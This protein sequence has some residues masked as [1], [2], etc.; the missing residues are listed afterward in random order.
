MASD[1]TRQL[2]KSSGF[3]YGLDLAGVAGELSESDLKILAAMERSK[4]ALTDYC[5]QNRDRLDQVLDAIYRKIVSALSGVDRRSFHVVARVVADY[6]L[7]YSNIFQN[8][9]DHEEGMY[10]ESLIHTTSAQFGDVL[11]RDALE[12]L[13]TKLGRKPEIDEA[14]AAWQLT[15]MKLNNEEEYANTKLE[16]A[17]DVVI[18]KMLTAWVQ[19]GCRQSETD[20]FGHNQL[21]LA[22]GYKNLPIG[23]EAIANRITTAIS[24]YHGSASAMSRYQVFAALL[25]PATEFPLFVFKGRSFQP[26][27]E[28]R[29]RIKNFKALDPGSVLVWICDECKRQERP[30]FKGTDLVPKN[31]RRDKRP[32]LNQRVALTDSLPFWALTE[33]R[34]MCNCWEESAGVLVPHF[35]QN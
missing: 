8:Q 6:S 7:A 28:E 24:K 19:L 16:V 26:I 30:G 20:I 23:R 27:R 14:K 35:G 13:T 25:F 33:S 21:Q 32:K 12:R 18:W 29:R 2:E 17:L 3:L 22:P 34:Y 4:E 31:V 15:W 9:A 10:W 5:E 11:Y 1:K